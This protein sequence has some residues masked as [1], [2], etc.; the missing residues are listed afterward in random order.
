MIFS[1]MLHKRRVQ[2]Q[3]KD[4][5]LIAVRHPDGRLTYHVLCRKPNFKKW[6]VK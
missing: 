2:R 5:I 6:R 4:M 1:T 3:L